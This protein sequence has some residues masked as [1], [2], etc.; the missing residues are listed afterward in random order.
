MRAISITSR[1]AF[2]Y[3]SRGMMRRTKSN[4]NGRDIVNLSTALTLTRGLPVSL[5]WIQSRNSCIAAEQVQNK[6]AKKKEMTIPF[7]AAR[8]LNRKP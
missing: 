5:H 8:G 3:R 1:R 2:D 7:I 4:C 6:S